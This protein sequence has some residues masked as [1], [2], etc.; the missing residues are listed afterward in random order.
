M[1]SSMIG[2]DCH[3]WGVHFRRVLLRLA[4]SAAFRSK[5]GNMFGLVRL[6]LKLIKESE[7]VYAPLDKE[8]GFAAVH[9]SSMQSFEQAALPVVFYRPT[10]LHYINYRTLAGEYNRLAS[11]IAKYTEN[12]SDAHAIKS[13]L[14]G[15]FAVPIGIQVKSHKQLGR[16]AGRT[17]TSSCVIPRL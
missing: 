14:S 9:V 6:A 11:D 7:F 5:C 17:H 12:P 8:P 10:F 15:A 3:R 1:C 16:Q 4:E 13:T 2:S